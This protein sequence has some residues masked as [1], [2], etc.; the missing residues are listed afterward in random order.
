MPQGYILPHPPATH[1]RRHTLPIISRAY[2][3]HAA[4]GQGTTAPTQ[5]EE[6]GHCG[7]GPGRQPY[8]GKVNGVETNKATVQAQTPEAL[9]GEEG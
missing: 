3:T 5:P 8:P 9:V 1:R 6:T 4:S 7:N 2:A